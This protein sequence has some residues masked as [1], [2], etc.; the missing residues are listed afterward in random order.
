M[1]G[2]LGALA[3][4]MLARNKT[5]QAVF[6]S[7]VIFGGAAVLTAMKD[8]HGPPIFVGAALAAVML[9]RSPL[10]KPA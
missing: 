5:P 6:G 1:A 4:W 9:K 3:V 7:I 8:I 2:L 10:S